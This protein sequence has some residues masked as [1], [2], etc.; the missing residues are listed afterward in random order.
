M[1]K[2]RE[3]QQRHPDQGAWAF[4]ENS[5]HPKLHQLPGP[6]EA[7]EK[8]AVGNEVEHLSRSLPPRTLR[9]APLHIG[10]H[11]PYR[12]NGEILSQPGL[13][14]S[15]W[16]AIPVESVESAGNPPA[17]RDHHSG[18]MK[19]EHRSPQGTGKRSA[20][21]AWQ[22]VHGTLGWI[23]VCRTDWTLQNSRPLLR[24]Q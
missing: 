8:H 7:S 20:R 19:E 3:T 10:A 13:W 22:G 6:P 23:A 21:A 9:Q 16:P 1:R 4:C 24:L 2:L 14:A 17:P 15:L 5:R 18:G 12:G 11:L